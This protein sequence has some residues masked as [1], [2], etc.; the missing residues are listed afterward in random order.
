MNAPGP[1]SP[2][3]DAGADEQAGADHAADGDHRQLPLVERLLQLRTRPGH[4]KPLPGQRLGGTLARSETWT[5]PS[6][7][8]A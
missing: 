1:V 5:I 3:T 7:D 6:I 4:L 2:M 8:V